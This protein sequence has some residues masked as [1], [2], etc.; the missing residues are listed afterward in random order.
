MIVGGLSGRGV[1][2]AASYEARKFG[3]RSAM[4]MFEAQRLCPKGVFVRPNMERYAEV[5][6]AVHRIFLEFTSEIEP[7]ALDEAFLDIT[8]SLN[9]LGGPLEIGKRVKQ[10]V[11]EAVNLTVSVG[12]APSKLVAKIACTSGKPDGLVFIERG[13]ERALLQPLPVR[14]LWGIGPVSAIALEKR[15]I[16]TIG[17]LA[18]CR[19]DEL[20][21][22][23]GNR[24][25]QLVELANGRDTRPVV[26]DREA[27]SYGEECTF[28][29]DLTVHAEILETITAHSEAVA[30]RLRRA[31]REGKTVTLKV[32][33]ARIARRRPDRL[34]I[35]DDAPEYPQM[36]RAR[37]LD[38]ATSDGAEIRRVA[39]A[40]WGE[41]ALKEPIRLLGVAVSKIERAGT[42]QLALFDQRGPSQRL[43]AT[44]D[45]IEA[46]FGRGA[47]RRGPEAVS[48]STPSAT[49]KR[50]E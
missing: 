3:V 15:G 24:S 10:R 45:A 21:S 25:A 4:P 12:I 23:L 9:L 38:A 28:D 13:M 11:R 16:G 49:R 34:R 30:R 8:H 37:T 42:G 27:K 39:V 29:V 43:G 47:V 19:P 44:L 33:L 18:Q 6:D 17:Q 14:R 1:V 41:L 20:A 2:S 36:T 32:K 48:K 35:T 22:L 7:I 31:E 40:L 5:S 26:S 46:R 50:G